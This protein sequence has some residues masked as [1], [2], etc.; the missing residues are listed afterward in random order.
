MYSKKKVY[1]FEVADW[2]TYFVGAL[3]WLVHNAKVCLNNLAKNGVKW[4]KN[5]LNGQMFDKI[6]RKAYGKLNTQIHL[7]NGKIL[8]AITSNSFISHKFTQFSDITFKTAKSYVDE[9]GKKYASQ[10]AKI[11]ARITTKVTTKGKKAILEVP[12]QKVKGEAWDAI[13]KYADDAGIE[14]REISGK[15]L[16][17]YNKYKK[18]FF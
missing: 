4:A 12:P 14:V 13:V 10:E 3:L 15:T 5:I 16:E 7:V 18:W 2:H 11:T 17:V 6:M 1:N 8:D 9:I